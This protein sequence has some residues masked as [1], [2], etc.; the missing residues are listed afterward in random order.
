MI[1]DCRL[2]PFLVERAERGDSQAV[3]QVEQAIEQVARKEYSFF[4]K[5]CG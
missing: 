1:R 4:S 3:V 5:A 2:D